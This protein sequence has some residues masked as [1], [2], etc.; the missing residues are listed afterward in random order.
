MQQ[1]LSLEMLADLLSG[2]I[3]EE[4]LR[5]RVVPHLLA[6]CPTC[7]GRVEAIRKLQ[8]R[9]DHWN[10]SVVVREGQEA[11][12]LLARLLE[13]PEDRRLQL[14]LA[15]EELHTWGL[16][17]LLMRKCR[18]LVH[19]EAHQALLLGEMAVLVAEQLPER[20][21]DRDW[22]GDLKA[23]A[24][25]VLGNARRVAGELTT[26]EVAFQRALALLEALAATGRPRVRAEVLD[27]LASLRREQ[28]RFEQSLAALAE[29]EALYRQDG[30]SHLVGRILLKRAKTLEELGHLENVLAE[31]QQVPELLDPQREPHLPAYVRH[32][33]VCCLAQMGRF[34]E[35]RESFEGLADLWPWPEVIQVRIQSLEAQIAAGLQ[36]WE[37]AEALFQQ[38]RGWF[39]EHDLP[40]DAALISLDLGALYAEQGRAAELETLAAEVLP[41]FHSLRLGREAA[42]SLIL[43]QKAVEQKSLTAELLREL[44]HVVEARQKRR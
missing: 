21:Y 33:L 3:A 2:E 40:F 5:E 8:D 10:E 38:V 4:D 43:F 24:W 29:A 35:A 37:S 42:A 12:R 20:S 31:L 39:V 9:F 32:N 41:L 14:L 1:H 16:A 18:E 44:R 13:Q 30:D 19:E 23:R 15:D 6:R 27:L 26:A 25:A 7:Q 22:L 17:Q 28:G 11:P 34:Q 36:E